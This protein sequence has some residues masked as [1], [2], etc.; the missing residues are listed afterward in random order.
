MSEPAFQQWQR[1]F[2]AHLRD[3]DRHGAPDG[4]EERRLAIY[5]E[6][7]FNTMNDILER[8]FPVLRSLYAEADWCRLVRAFLDGH[9]CRTP[10][11][12]KI[13]GEFVGFLAQHQAGEG[14]PPFLAELAH[15]EWVELDLDID[16]SP[17]PEQG[18]DIAGDPMAAPPYLT[19]LCRVLQYRWPVH[20]ITA[21]F[22]PE[23]PAE[24]TVWLLGFR[25]SAAEV[26]FM[27]I[28]APTARLLAL[29]DA[30]PQ[31]SGEALLRRLAEEMAHP[32][33]QAI[34]G[35]G[36][37]LFAGWRRREVLLGTRDTGSERV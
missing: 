28:N 26:G 23:A 22:L 3:P 17:W 34:L 33:P 30:F 15:Y 18:L 31:D 11:F 8:A 5:R 2:A 25:N 19:P 24:Q 12:V 35:F 36:A 37:E 6:L 32:D 7:I 27:E 9:R 13:P 1:Q 4:I 20:R 14:D 16:A 29:I 21:D 10:Y